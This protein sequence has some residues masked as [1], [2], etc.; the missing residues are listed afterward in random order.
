M[1]KHFET[2]ETDVLPGAINR[3]WDAVVQIRSSKG[4]AT[5]FGTGFLI[6]KPP[7]RISFMEKG[8]RVS[9]LASFKMP[10]L[11]LTNHHVVDEE[12]THKEAVFFYDEPGQ[13][14]HRVPLGSLVW[15]SNATS[16]QL[17]E[18]NPN[19]LDYTVWELGEL[20]PAVAERIIAL[21]NLQLEEA[22]PVAAESLA[23]II[24]HPAGGPKRA[25]FAAILEK[26]SDH[27][28]VLRYQQSATRPGSSGSP[29]IALDSHILSGE[30]VSGLHYRSEL[31]VTFRAGIMDIR[32][33]LKLIP[34][35]EVFPD[36]A[37]AVAYLEQIGAQLP[38]FR[39]KP[40]KK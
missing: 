12:A 37:T 30:S 7:V 34:P 16:D 23:L 35:S 9:P 8:T 31:A 5:V 32:D 33:Y 25:S 36:R 15:S 3:A 2:C 17:R 27:C 14:S 13:N 1:I 11:L 39:L 19:H 40:R 28:S 4:F 26:Q 29:V 20:S 22:R 24:G 6:Q 21:E 10:H 18:A 38:R